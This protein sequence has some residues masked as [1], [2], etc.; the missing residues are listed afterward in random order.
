VAASPP[1]YNSRPSGKTG[2]NPAGADTTSAA[3]NDPRDALGAM[4]CFMPAIRLSPSG[5][6]YQPLR[7]PNKSTHLAGLIFP[8]DLQPLKNQVRDLV[9]HVPFN[10]NVTVGGFESLN[11]ALVKP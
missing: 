8:D 9:G 4:L 6:L 3:R 7:L 1:R 11:F 5:L 2:R 10:V